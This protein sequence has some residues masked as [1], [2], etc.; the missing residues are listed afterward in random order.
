MNRNAPSHIYRVYTKTVHA[1]HKKTRVLY[2]HQFELHFTRT[3]SLCFRAADLMS[4]TRLKSEEIYNRERVPSDSLFV[5][6][7]S[8]NRTNE[9]IDQQQPREQPPSLVEDVSEHEDV[10]GPPPLPKSNDASRQKSK[11]SNF[12]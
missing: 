5:G 10:F 6:R 1:C 2:S 3:F 7:T 4:S 11:V 12:F 8:N 9:S